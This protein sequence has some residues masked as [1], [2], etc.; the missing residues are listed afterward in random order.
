MAEHGMVLDML[1]ESD[2]INAMDALIKIPNSGIS[3]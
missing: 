2:V 3:L 1:T